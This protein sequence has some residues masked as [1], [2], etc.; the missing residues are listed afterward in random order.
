ML[1]DSLEKNLLLITE[2]MKDNLT[3][4]VRRFS[5]KGYGKIGCAL[6]FCDGLVNSAFLSENV[7]RPV[8]EAPLITKNNCL[9]ILEKSFIDAAEIKYAYKEEEI[10]NA[11]NSGDAVL[12]AGDE[13]RALVISAKGYIKRANNEPEGEGVTIGSHEG[14]VEP[15]IHNLAMLRRRLNT[16][17][18]KY[19][20]YTFGTSIKTTAAVCYIEGVAS[21][22]V[23]EKLTARL[24][25]IKHQDILNINAIGER[26]QN[27]PLSPFKTVA[28]TERP[29]IVAAKLLEGRVA[30][31]LD[32]TA[33][34]ITLPAVFLEF[35]QTGDD[36]YVNYIYSSFNRILRIICFFLTIS[37]PAL[38]V[39]TL[40]FHREL[41]PTNLL[42][43]IAA[44]R[45]GVPF[46]V[47]FETVIILVAFDI[48][49]DTGA[50]VSPSMGQSL[51]IVGALILGDAAVSARFISA[52]LLIIAAATGLTGLMN[53]TIR[54]ATL[55][56]RYLL[57]GLG[58]VGGLYGYIFGIFIMLI[59]LCRQESFGV[60]YTMDLWPLSK[61]QLRD[62]L[63]RENWLFQKYRNIFRRGL[64]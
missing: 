64:K 10:I 8:L 35:F 38:Y 14:F 6:L 29:D 59:S 52:P 53:S 58:A 54:S 9:S 42:I 21:K 7:V 51:S 62:S 2:K 44:A 17:N 11:L 55:L 15:L 63:I 28:K 33:A 48:L 56:W 46:P 13:S 49:R 5:C 25:K 45:S 22:K 4:K 24:D 37:I 61:K 3:F 41:L 16:H 47:L 20:D 34:V 60:P 27:N 32:G 19:I 1:T 26:I 18:L 50:H 39:A 43:S 36:Y 40:N 12:F 23:I 30:I 31:I 57:L